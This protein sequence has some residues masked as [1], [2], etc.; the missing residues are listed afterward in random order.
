MGE[1]V[2]NMSG[3][4]PVDLKVLVLPDPVD[5]K[6]GG[7]LYLPQETQARERMAQTT[8]TLVACGGG[9]F[10]DWHEPWPGPG[11]RVIIDRY[12]GVR[13]DG[14][15]GEEYQLI[16]DADILAVLIKEKEE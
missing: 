7:G 5:E 14:A 10:K 8:A 6:T 4:K 9:A 13:A 15:D 11:N 16:N 1:A 12:A 3:I 2:V